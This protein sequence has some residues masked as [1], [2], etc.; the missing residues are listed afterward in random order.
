MDFP[1]YLAGEETQNLLVLQLNKEKGGASLPCLRY[2]YYA[3]QLIPILHWSNQD[4]KANW[5]TIEFSIATTIADN[6]RSTRRPESL[7]K[8][9]SQNI[10]KSS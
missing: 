5:K 7:D 1:L 2:Y 9:N 6:C 8:S 10:A 3:S 4:Y